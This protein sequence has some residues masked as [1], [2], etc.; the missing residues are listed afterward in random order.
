MINFLTNSI[1]CF[2]HL[3]YCFDYPFK[4]LKSRGQLPLDKHELHY[5]P[6][7]PELDKDF[8]R[9]D[10][11]VISARGFSVLA[12]A[13]RTVR[14]GLIIGT[15]I[16]QDALGFIEAFG[17]DQ[18]VITDLDQQ[19]A[20]GA[21][22]N[23][24]RNVNPHFGASDRVI[25]TKDRVI[26]IES[27]LFENKYLRGKKFDIIFENLPNLPSSYREASDQPMW[28][29]FCYNEAGSIPPKYVRGLLASH[30]DCLAS[31]KPYLEAGGG[32]ICNIGARVSPDLILGMFDELGYT[33]Q[34]LIFDFK[35]Q[36]EM[37]VNLKAYARW[38]KINPGLEFSFYP[39]E[40]T[41]EELARYQYNKYSGY[42]NDTRLSVVSPAIA[43]LELSAGEA[44]QLYLRDNAN[45]SGHF[46]YSIYAEPKT[47]HHGKEEREDLSRR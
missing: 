27:N 9:N 35:R 23:I 3:S 18:L 40:K 25:A 30:Y 43:A 22:W 41:L 5:S 47:N 15:G 33:A 2:E 14:K 16:G 36:N 17:P 4:R 32:I 21:Q 1:N 26:A 45:Q 28:G 20:R 34:V 44:Y 19:I 46:Y 37:N 11:G 6:M 31:A 12:M 10:W 7:T 24:I 38:E 42:Y 29:S 39:Y 8:L 13:G